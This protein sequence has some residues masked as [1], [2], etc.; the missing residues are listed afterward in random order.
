M[1]AGRLVETGRLA[2]TGRRWVEPYFLGKI[3][4]IG[5]YGPRQVEI[6]LFEQ[7][8]QDPLGVLDPSGV[9]CA[10]VDAILK[11]LAGLLHDEFQAVLRVDEL[12]QSPIVVVVEKEDDPCIGAQ[13]TGHFTRLGHRT[14]RC[15]DPMP[16][17]AIDRRCFR[18]LLASQ[19]RRFRSSWEASK[20]R[21][22]RL[23]LQSFAQR[24]MV[25]FAGGE[26]MPRASPG[27]ARKVG[28][29]I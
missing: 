14:P 29:R 26:S 11:R 2:K 3:Q 18:N 19:T 23:F 10:P 25:R 16:S 28:E 21:V 6:V 17:L 13:V 20:S 27:A 15:F 1:E 12:Q 4:K 22:T 7:Q 5:L 9:L 8:Q 24:P